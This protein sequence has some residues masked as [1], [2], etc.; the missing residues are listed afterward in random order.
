MRM[1]ENGLKSGWKNN[2]MTIK[3]V[4]IFNILIGLI[5][6]LGLYLRFDLYFFE[7]SIWYD[8]AA[9]WAN[10]KCGG[11]LD[12][13]KTLKYN[14]AAPIGFLVESKALIKLFG[15]SEY[16]LR[17]IPLLAGVL[18]LFVFYWFC[19]LFLRCKNAKLFAMMLFAVN[20]NLIYYSQEFKQ[21]SSD[22]LIAMF[23]A[24]IAIEFKLKRPVLL[25]LFFALCMWYSHAAIL[26]AGGIWAA[27]LMRTHRQKVYKNFSIFTLILALNGVLYY[28]LSLKHLQHQSFLNT[29]WRTSFI[30][31]NLSNL[32]DLIVHNFYFIFQPVKL[33]PDS[34]AIWTPICIFALFIAGAIIAFKQDRIGKFRF[35]ILLFPYF[36]ILL[37]SYFHIYPYYD[38]VTLFLTPF[39]TV[40]LAKIFDKLEK[41]HKTSII[42]LILSALILINPTISAQKHMK[43][44]PQQDRAIFKELMKK[45]K[46]GEIVVTNPISALSFKY[47]SDRYGFLPPMIEE[48]TYKNQFEYVNFLLNLDKSNGYWFYTTNMFENYDTKPL[49]EFWGQNK[50]EFFHY[51]VRKSDLY[52]VK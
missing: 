2:D 37:A 8:E 39:F 11:F 28:F 18:S 19:G 33:F 26:V 35:T 13:F 4:W 38:R 24:I 42:I 27:F 9:L 12:L 29:V 50:K 10:I 1:R 16:I 22:V 45:Y 41:Y 43:N 3:R 51:N 46:L 40:T 20:S 30:E 25:G 17:F 47:Y 48:K 15:D 7:R 21:Y 23:L 49:I 6:A 52:Y 34:L 5:L 32:F 36:A 14:Q 44:L 31:K